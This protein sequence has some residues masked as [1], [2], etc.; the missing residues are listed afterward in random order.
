MDL[1]EYMDEAAR[2]AYLWESISIQKKEDIASARV[3]RKARHRKAWQAAIRE[4]GMDHCYKCGY[5]EHIEGLNFHYK[6]PSEKIKPISVLMTQKA[7]P[8]NLIELKKT[9]PLCGT[10]HQLCQQG[11]LEYPPMPL[12]LPRA[13]PRPTM[14]PKGG[15][16]PMPRARV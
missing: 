7:S 6:N 2:R 11:K 10:C 15:F 5:N 1:G 4:R 13:V 3:E 9:M 14:S 16:V 12:M 8:K